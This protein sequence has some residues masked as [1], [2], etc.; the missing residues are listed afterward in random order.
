[1]M[2]FSPRWGS[3]V[4]LQPT[5]D[6]SPLGLLA[7]HLRGGVCQPD[8]CSRGGNKSD[9]LKRD[10]DVEQAHPVQSR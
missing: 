2:A 3:S 5:V 10:A 9:K 7:E 1:M 8:G 4:D 6:S